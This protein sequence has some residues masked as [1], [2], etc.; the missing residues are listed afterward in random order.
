M[1]SV[2]KITINHASHLNISNY[3]R[4]SQMYCVFLLTRQ[5]NHLA[6]LAKWLSVRLRIK[7]MWVR[8]P[9]QSVKCTLKPIS[10]AALEY[11]FK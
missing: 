1:K 6:S 8:V 7:W 4:N 5:P 3:C 9:L 2:H 11:G 10:T